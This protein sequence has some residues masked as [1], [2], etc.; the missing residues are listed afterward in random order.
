MRIR[1]AIAV[2]VIAIIASA[3]GGDA[4]PAG[5]AREVG[6]L[7]V[8][9]A[10]VVLTISGAVGQP[11]VGDEVQ[12][13]LAGIESLGTVDVTIFEPFISEEIAFTGV[14]LETVLRAAGIGEDVPLIWTALDDYQ[15]DFTL[16]EL[17]EDGALLA[18]RQAGEPLAIA[19][20]GPI[21]V[22]FTETDGDLAQNTNEWI[23]SLVR[24]D[25]G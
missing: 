15:V 3:C 11:N 20:G 2:V 8:P 10:E 1:S 16:A 24:V 6:P 14:P 22:I 5:V 9:T 7:P 4:E 13:D 12:A 18:T 19:D 25:A 23:W 17:A 21:R